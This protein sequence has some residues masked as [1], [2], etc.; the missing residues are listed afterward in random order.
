MTI[1]SILPTARTTFLDTNANPL[2]GGSVYFYVPPN[3]TTLKTTWQDASATIPN[4]NPVILDGNGS[5]L[6]YGSGQYLQEVYDSAGNLVYTGLTQDPYGLLTGSNNTWTGTNTF[7]GA[8]VFG[9]AVTLSNGSVTNAM[10]ANMAANTVK[11]NNTAGLAAPIDATMAQFNAV[12]GSVITIK[13]Q[14]ITATNTYTPSAGMLYCIA[15]AVGSGGGGG[16][17]NGSSSSGGGGGSGGY[18]RA[19]LTAAQIG[20]SKAVT[21]GAAGTAG[22]N[23][24]GSGGNGGD[25]SLGSLLVVKGGSGGSGTTA[26]SGYTAGGLGGLASGGTGD[27]LINGGAGFAGINT[28]ASVCYPGYGGASFFS[29]SAVSTPGA[30]AAGTAGNLYGGG[31]SGA[32]GATHAGGAGALGCVYIQEFCSK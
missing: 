32:G 15:E 12:L 22:A 21:I 23:T 14:L 24:G 25:V 8:V 29:A 3:T 9:G 20:A 30:G 13:K 26:T 31:G 28:G 5:A 18:G 17:S 19:T 16:G 10:L 1:A 4:T 2:S 6:I 11:M 27:L 7:N